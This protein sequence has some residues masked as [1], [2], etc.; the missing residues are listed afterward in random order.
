[1][2]KFKK[3]KMAS[4]MMASLMLLVILTSMGN[5]EGDANGVKVTGVTVS[6][7]TLS[8]AVGST[9]TLTAT[10]SPSDATDKVVRWASNKGTVAMVN[11]LTGV[12]TAVAPGTANITVS[13]NDGNKNTTCAVTVYDPANYVAVTSVSVSPATLSLVVGNSATLTATVSPA[14]A[15]VKTVE[16]SSSNTAVATVSNYGVTT[17]G[18]GTATITATTTDG[19]KT[20]TCAVTVTPNTTVAV[21][22][23]SVSPTS[24]SLPVGSRGTLTETVLPANATNKTVTWSSSNT[25]IATVNADTVTAVAAG[26]ATITVKTVDGNKTATCAVTVIPTVLI[27]GLVITNSVINL[28]AIGAT[29]T[30]NLYIMPEN[31]TNKTMIYATET[32]GVASIDANG[33]VTALGAGNTKFT[34]TTTDGSTNDDGSPKSDFGYIYVTLD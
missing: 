6:P 15:T 5:C 27:E 20:A 12:V 3:I 2:E 30:I 25:A 26:T 10:I 11:S 17:I 32:P 28:N 34:V 8:L 18:V 1:M 33:V 24:L 31:A 7:V 13:T 9:G 16:W 22:S 23:V 14:T 4:L 21:E 29:A 19:N